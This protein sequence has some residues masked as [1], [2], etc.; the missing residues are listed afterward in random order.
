MGFGHEGALRI[1]VRGLDETI[2]ALGAID[3]ELPSELRK[4][5]RE[6]ARPLLQSARGYASGLGG[7]GSYASSLSMRTVR[8]G[9]R[10][11]SGDPGAGTIEFALPGAFALT[12][13]RRGRPIGVPRGTPARALVRAA[14]E[15]EPDITARASRRVEQAIERYLNG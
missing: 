6:D 14:K 9:V 3:R 1:E 8:S 12:G 2:V 5:L 4:G 10:I 13:P 11:V 15:H 7:T